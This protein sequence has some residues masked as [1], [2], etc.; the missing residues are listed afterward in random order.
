[1]KK[2]FD[3]YFSGE[4]LEGYERD[5]VK[6]AVGSLFGL[7]G[8]KLEALFSG[9]PVRIKKNL[10]TERA[11]RLRKKFLEL[12]ALVQIVPAGSEP[13][14]SPTGTPQPRA[15]HPSSPSTAPPPARPADDSLSLAPQAPLK[16]DSPTGEETEFRTPSL[17]LSTPDGSPLVEEETVEPPPLPDIGGLS[18]APLEAQGQERPA[19]PAP[20]PPDISH[21]EMAPLDDGP[22]EPDRNREPPP[23]PDISGLSLED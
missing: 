3:V 20:P 15:T 5:S 22:E 9:V 2:A 12:G 1:M 6:A 7:A 23:L 21:L 14:D 17:T 8:P 16:T 10:D 4:L 18:L 19:E 13:P 11:G